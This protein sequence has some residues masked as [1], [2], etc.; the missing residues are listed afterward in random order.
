VSLKIRPRVLSL[1]ELDKLDKGVSRR[2]SM[3][4]R[5]M[6]S[7]AIAILLI[8]GVK[9]FAIAAS[10]NIQDITQPH[11]SQPDCKGDRTDDCRR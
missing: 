7:L 10:L 2:C 8:L 11:Q 9:S 5:L 1:P 4:R 3:K 6:T